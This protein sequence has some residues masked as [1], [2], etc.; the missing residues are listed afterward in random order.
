M[1]CIQHCCCHREYLAFRSLDGYINLTQLK[2]TRKKLLIKLWVNWSTCLAMSF[3]S[4][5]TVTNST[6]SILS[7]PADF[8]ISNSSSAGVVFETD[9]DS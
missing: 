8:S 7:I 9:L 6:S 1:P 4:L 2:H 5:M 3:D